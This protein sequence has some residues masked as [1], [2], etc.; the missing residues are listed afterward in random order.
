MFPQTSEGAN[1]IIK[2]M[3]NITDS[4][5]GSKGNYHSSMKIWDRDRA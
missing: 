2:S 5:R 1:Q 3:S 4:D